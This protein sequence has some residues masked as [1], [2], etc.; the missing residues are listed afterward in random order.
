MFDHEPFYIGKGINGRAYQLKRRKDNKYLANKLD[1]FYPIILKVKEGLAENVAYRE[2]IK[3]IA[4]IGRWDKGTG[5]LANQTDGGDGA[6]GNKQSPETIAKRISKTRGLKR[7]D[8]FRLR[9]SARLKWKPITEQHMQRIVAMGKAKTGT[10]WTDEQRIKFKQSRLGHT[11]SPETRA[12]LYFIN[13]GRIFT[14]EHKKNISIGR[15]GRITTEETRKR[16]SIAS[17]LQWERRKTKCLQ[18]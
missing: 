17:K 2:E 9:A 12:K 14:E 15:Q 7:T 10:R 16:M 3:M 18:F 8:E 6:T 4:L 5:P 13:K 1:K 11:V